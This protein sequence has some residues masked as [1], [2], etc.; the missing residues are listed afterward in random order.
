MFEDGLHI[1]AVRVYYEDTD[2][3]G[4]VYYANYLRFAERARTEFTRAL[5]FSHSRLFETAGIVF[6]VRRCAAEFLAPARLDDLLA[7]RSGITGVGGASVDMAQ[8]VR[9][10]DAD[11]VRLAVTLACVG[12]DGRPA[13]IPAPVRDA[14]IRHHQLSGM[15]ADQW[16]P[17]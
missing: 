8:T 14:L 17:P 9:R 3:A 16:T 7:V 15:P 12:P 5:G 1:F 11:L 13:R 4:I 6:A 10:G 2:A